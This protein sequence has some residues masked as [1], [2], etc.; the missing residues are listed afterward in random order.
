MKN[1]ICRKSMWDY[2]SG[3][4]AK[5]IDTEA[6]DY[7]TTLEVWEIDNSKIIACVNN[8]TI[9]SVGAQLTKYDTAKEV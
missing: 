9:Y 5:L 6:D 4:K 8:S 1:F 3:A 2:I 7:A